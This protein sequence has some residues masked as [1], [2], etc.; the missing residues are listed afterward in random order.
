MAPDCAPTVAAIEANSRQY[1]PAANKPWEA[2]FPGI[3][4]VKDGCMKT[5]ALTEPGLGAV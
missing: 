2:K 5:D 1:V 3:F 4:I